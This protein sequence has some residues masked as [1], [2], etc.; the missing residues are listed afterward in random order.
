MTA[1]KP[2]K[3]AEVI[4]KDTFRYGAYEARI[5]AAKGGGV[6]TPFFLW[7]DGSELPGAQWQEQDFEVFG[8]DGCF[9]TQAMT[10]GKP[11]AEHVVKHHPAIPVYDRY[12]T[13]RMEWTPDSI[14]FYGSPA[15]LVE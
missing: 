7:K 9:Q 8:H 5:R 15:N 1:A 10:P 11:R 12:N 6:I 14:A 3:G 13:Y 2:W 4:S